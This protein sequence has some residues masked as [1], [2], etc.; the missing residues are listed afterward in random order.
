MF[1]FAHSL[2]LAA[3]LVLFATVQAA[4][5]QAPSTTGFQT[6]SSR[7]DC[8]VEPH[9][10]A[11]DPEVVECHARFAPLPVL[12]RE[13]NPENAEHVEVLRE[14]GDVLLR[15]LDRP[16]A[17]GKRAQVG[18]AQACAILVY[19]LDEEY[20]QAGL[21]WTYVVKIYRTTHPR[22]A[23][24]RDT[25]LSTVE[26]NN[27]EARFGPNAVDGEVWQLLAEQRAKTRC[28]LGASQFIRDTGS[29]SANLHRNPDRCNQT[30][31]DVRYRP[32]LVIGRGEAERVLNKA[33]IRSN[34][35]PA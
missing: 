2:R 17:C 8:P 34:F 18:I 25:V 22:K 16:E 1:A 32:M 20:R 12:P 19:V 24:L 6:V 26:S 7:N 13:I 35:G 27:S 28:R 14:M 11:I 30:G 3:G 10:K 21:P 23:R 4:A 15:Q 33:S 9:P 31:K 5:A 29:V